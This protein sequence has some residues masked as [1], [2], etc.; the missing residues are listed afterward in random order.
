MHAA[1]NLDLFERSGGHFAPP[2]IQTLA[3]FL[4]AR[5]APDE[6]ATL[7]EADGL[8][9][10]V[11]IGPEVIPTSEWM[12]L[13]WGEE[14][15]FDSREQ[16]S[17]MI[18]ALLRRY[19][20]IILSL[21]AELP[22]YGPVLMQNEAGKVLASDWAGGFVAGMGLR[23]KAWGR[24]I[25]ARR[26]RELI[27]PIF[28][29][30]PE[31]IDAFGERTPAEIAELQQDAAEHIPLCVW[32]ISNYWR[33]RRAARA[34]MTRTNFSFAVKVGRNQACPCGSGKKFKKCC[35]AGE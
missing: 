28:I 13:V 19:N 4:N 35:G 31:A 32:G 7:S 16:A 21:Q 11:A 24:L 27:A 22:S 15:L 29:L 34:G 18:T 17:R 33:E 1:G 9:T 30:L 12:P 5:D 25:N 8:L 23:A 10:A 26:D 6:R 3:E 14:P 2:D 20:D